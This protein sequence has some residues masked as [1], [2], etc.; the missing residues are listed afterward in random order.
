MPE[1]D[2]DALRSRFPALA[3][4][5][6]G[7][8]VALFDGPGGTQVP[9]TVIEAVSRYYR[10]SNANHEG[11]FLTS[12]RSDAVLED[13]HA[14]LA[15]LLNAADASEIKFGANMTT[16]TMHVARSI[17]ASL[18]PGD[19]I[20]VT[21]LD[22]EANVGPWRSA[23]ADRGITVRTVD[24]RPDDVT[25]DVEA[26]R[27]RAPRATEAGR[28]RLG[29]ERRRLHQPGRRARPARARGGGA[30][31]RR[32][33]PRRAP[34]ADR[35]PGRGHR[36]P[37]LLGLQ[38]LRAARRASSTGAATS[39]TP[40]RPTSCCR[41]TTGSRP[42]PSTTRGSPGRWRRW[43]TSPRS[44]AAT[45]RR[46]PPTFPGMTGRRLDAH[47]GMAAIR[48]YEMP[49]FGRLLD[50]L[51]TVPGLR[52]WGI[53]DRA[54]FDE[55]TPTAAITLAGVTRRGGLGRARRAGDRDLVG[56][57]LRG[58][59]HR[60]ASASSPRACCAS[61]SPTTTRR[62]RSTGWSASCARSP[63]AASVSPGV[64]GAADV[65]IIG[66]GIV[67]TA[68]AAD[69]AGR[70]AR[71]TLFERA[72]IAAGAS[73]RNSGVVWYPADP[74]LGALYRES[75]AMYRMLVSEIGRG[76]PG[77]C[78]RARHSASTTSRRAS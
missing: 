43:S 15:D 7:E 8:P 66:G 52:L 48:A 69:L 33:G 4:E 2:V 56:Q 1:F 42:G 20:V 61:A 28:L 30:D 63:P 54:R 41:R 53:A 19:E 9:D 72:G 18:A 71:V 14:A 50:G 35:R 64:S 16:L 55:R 21:S 37:R 46:S 47:V 59:A 76:A 49:L 27:R 23:A 32:R 34:P 6:G 29:L 60:S 10:E 12:Q 13:A 57:L 62:R 5:Q 65:A 31:L 73:G 78:P 75:L 25:L 11:P 77:R 3:I 58:R 40:C 74:V 68:L 39:S 44:G 26:V 22:H 24:I 45:G 17:T 70:G 36:L 67:G 51:A 38:V